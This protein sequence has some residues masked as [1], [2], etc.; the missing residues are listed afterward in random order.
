MNLAQNN[1]TE[2]I[3]DYLLEAYR[4]ETASKGK[5]V[6]LGQN[7]LNSRRLKEKIDELKKLGVMITL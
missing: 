5:T 3:L 2:K 7:Q 6:Q 4:K 1:F